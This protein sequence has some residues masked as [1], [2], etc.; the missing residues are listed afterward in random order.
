MSFSDWSA[1]FA[2]VFPPPP[3]NKLFLIE[4]FLCCTGDGLYAALCIRFSEGISES[5]R[6]ETR[7][8]SISA[9]ITD[10]R[11]LCWYLIHYLYVP[12]WASQNPSHNSGITQ[13]CFPLFLLFAFLHKALPCWNK[14]GVFMWLSA[15]WVSRHFACAMEDSVWRRHFGA[16]S[17]T[18][19]KCDW[20][21]PI[22]GCQ[23]F[24]IWLIPFSLQEME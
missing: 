2:F 11:L 14:C 24:C 7:Q 17:R 23:L 21:D 22:C 6:W 20:S 18:W 10:C 9:G 4:A 12:T 15:W 8:A 1:S 19:S 13:N 16:L 3:E 5:K